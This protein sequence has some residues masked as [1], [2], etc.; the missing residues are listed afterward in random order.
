MHDDLATRMR[1]IIS[2]VFRLWH[3]HIIATLSIAGFGSI[4][5]EHVMSCTTSHLS[6]YSSWT[7]LERP[8]PRPNILGKETA[9]FGKTSSLHFGFVLVPGR[10]WPRGARGGGREPRAETNVLCSYHELLALL[11]SWNRS[12][13][14]KVVT[15]TT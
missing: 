14:G 1:Y 5:D 6:L 9:R 3:K 8:R 10:V 11:S 15:R 13:A 4:P 12:C 7:N 2:F